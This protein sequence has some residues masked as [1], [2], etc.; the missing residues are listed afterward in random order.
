MVLQTISAIYTDLD[1]NI[2]VAN[3][4]LASVAV[5]SLIYATDSGKLYVMS[6]TLGP[7]PAGQSGVAYSTAPS[8]DP[9][10]VTSATVVALGL[11]SGPGSTD[12]EPAGGVA[13][14]V[15]TTVIAVNSATSFF[16]GELIL[17][18]GAT[19]T[20]EICQIKSISG[21][22]FTLQ[23]PTLKAHADSGTVVGM[24][25]G[26]TPQRSGRLK[27]TV[28]GTIVLGSAASTWTAQIYIGS[29]ITVAAPANATAFDASAVAVGNTQEAISGTGVLEFPYSQTVFLGAN[30]NATDTAP[31]GGA[32]RTV[33]TP[34]YVDVGV[35]SS[36]GTI[37]LIEPSIVIEEA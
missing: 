12:L 27:I 2:T 30:G 13:Y 10:A 22:N 33:G 1:A 25:A 37:Q 15:G 31:S 20:A 35:T 6:A 21:T 32:A 14:P 26:I 17:I 19:A 4:P 36:T 3:Y 24:Y 8:T 23:S 34:Y 29:A 7:V 18:E 16:Q 28:S 11:A 9:S 5:G